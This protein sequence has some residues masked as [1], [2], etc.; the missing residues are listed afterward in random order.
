MKRI[1]S[2][3]LLTIS[4]SLWAQGDHLITREVDM[5]VDE[6]TNK[7]VETIKAEGLTLFTI[8]D[9]SANAEK[10][11]M[12]LPPSRLLIFGNPKVGTQ[13]MQSDASV[14]IELPLKILVYSSRGQ[15]LVSYTAPSSYVDEYKLEKHTILLE[16]VH[17]K[18]GSIITI[19]LQD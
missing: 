13:L 7:L 3:L 6:A 10:A 5:E 15:T 11:G 18:L 2:L 9:H 14:G 4:T 8:I 1:L 16:K 17:K 12:E 19:A